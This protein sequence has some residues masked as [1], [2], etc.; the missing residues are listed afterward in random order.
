MN[1]RIFSLLLIVPLLVACTKPATI[2]IGGETE[3]SVYYDGGSN[4][5]SVT[6]DQD[7]TATSSDAWVKVSPES[8]AASDQPVT[9]TITS[10]PNPGQE[11]RTATVTIAAGGTSKTVTVTQ[12]AAPDY[13]AKAAP[14]L[15]NGDVVLA[16]SELTE[17]FLTEVN[18]P[19]KDL[20]FTKIFD[21]Y[22][23]FNGK[24]LNWSNWQANWPNGD[25]PNSYSIRWAPTADYV[26][27]KLQ[28]SDKL[29][30][31]REQ[32][33]KAGTY[34]VD[35]TNL[36][37]NDKYTYK[38]TTN[39]DNK[40]VVAEGTFETTGHLHQVFF[41]GNCRNAR[42]L[43]GWKTESGKTLK[44]RKIYRGGRMNDKWETMLT[45]TG[46]KDV[47]AE[48]I[49]AELE[50]R[51]SDDY[52]E[53]PA[54]EEFDY[55][56]PVIEEGG[57]VMLGVSKPSAKNCAKWLKFDQGRSEIDVSAYSPTQA[58]YDAFQVAYKAK[59]KECFEFV[60]NCVKNNKPVYFHCSLGRDR[61][62]T[63]G[64]LIMGVLG[65]REGDISKEYELTYFAPVGFSVSSSDK[66]NN[67]EPIFKNDRT[68]WVYSDIVPYFWQ[69]AGSGSF[70]SGVEKYLVEEAG[71]SKA[72]I[73]E[74][75]SLML[76]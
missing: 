72:A 6:S 57:K 4:T 74:F 75:R 15:K 48:G 8:G 56:K 63:M 36:V 11:E 76:E 50:L 51:G 47:Q 5:I 31:S 21:Y 20:S 66:T 55:C 58:E 28:L 32:E 19:D 7:W 17:K 67:P 37:P 61:T 65:V 70:A 14:E 52:C 18:Y 34:Y 43:G 16:N 73:D 54:L 9:V 45:S 41:K 53:K 38:V 1:K 2:A 62:G 10:E 42:D 44:Y 22:G 46:K 40:T 3:I 68:H 13:Y 23:G 35:I 27:Y 33:I 29:G 12:E 49:R 39:D 59:T 64:V 60:M 30:W 69:K 26:G 71:V 24:D 25:K